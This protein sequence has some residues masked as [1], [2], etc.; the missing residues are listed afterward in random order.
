MCTRILV[1]IFISCLLLTRASLAAAGDERWLALSR[2]QIMRL[3][4]VADAKEVHDSKSA[5]R[6]VL[7]LHANGDTVWVGINQ[8]AKFRLA[9]AGRGEQVHSI[10]VFVPVVNL[11]KKQ[12]YE[13]VK[14]LTGFFEAALPEW[15]EARKW[16]EQ[17][18]SLSWSAAANA[19]ERKPFDPENI[20]AK[21]TI[22]GVTV[23][24]FG[25]P[26]DI[27]LYAA[28]TRQVCIPKLQPRDSKDVG[29]DPIQ[30]LVC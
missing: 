15:R 11:S 20:I 6:D 19:M 21:K 7:L 4:E 29:N 17:S 25:V 22:A 24:T 8:S 18:M 14:M 2:A 9:M 5:P 27:I 12:G 30:R 1:S 3:F 26:P 23:S 13:T 28:T 10:R 16:P